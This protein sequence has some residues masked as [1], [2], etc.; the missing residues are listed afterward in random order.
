[1]K[2]DKTLKTKILEVRAINLNRI[3]E[4]NPEKYEYTFEVEEFEKGLIL[5][6][7]CDRLTKSA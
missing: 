3:N 7:G 5:L 1:M 4:P 6:A 2:N